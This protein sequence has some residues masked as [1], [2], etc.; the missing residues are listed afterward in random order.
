MSGERER[1]GEVPESVD[2]ASGSPASA[3]PK[4]EESR[5]ELDLETAFAD[6]VARYGDPA[7]ATGPWPSAEDVD[8]D[9]VTVTTAAADAWPDP[10]ELAALDEHFVPPDVPPIRG[11]DLVSRAAWASVIG[12]P[13]VL[14]VAAMV[15]GVVPSMLL[16]AA[17]VAFIGGFVV[18]VARMPSSPATDDGQDGA[19]I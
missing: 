8:P 9:P 11:G 12:G 4:A 18:L 10:P 3:A 19:V 14:L 5:P 13:L 2:P 16:G 1:D 7:P 6:I 15:G 17:L